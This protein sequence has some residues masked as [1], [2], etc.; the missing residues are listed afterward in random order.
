[1]ILKFMIF[2]TTAEVVAIS[3]Q[4]HLEKL[5]MVIA[6]ITLRSAVLPCPVYGIWQFQMLCIVNKG[7][8]SL[9]SCLSV[10]LKSLLLQSST[11]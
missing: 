11:S 2:P 7:A 3:L 9:R 10:G 4:R 6:L 8:A 5:K 1:M